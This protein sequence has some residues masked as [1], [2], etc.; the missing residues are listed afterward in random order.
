MDCRLIL[1]PPFPLPVPRCSKNVF[2]YIF[3]AMS[4]LAEAEEAWLAMKRNAK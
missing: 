3:C 4:L 1:V 2:D